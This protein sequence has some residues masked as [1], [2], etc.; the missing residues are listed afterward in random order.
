MMKYMRQFTDENNKEQSREKEGPDNTA[1]RYASYFYLNM[2]ILA[3]ALERNK[4]DI[5]YYGNEDIG[6]L[7]NIRLYYPD[8]QP[9]SSYVYLINAEDTSSVLPLYKDI[10]FIVKGKT[11]SSLLSDRRAA[12]ILMRDP[13]NMLEIFTDMQKVFDLYA[14]WNW[15]LQT[16]VEKS[17]P[18]DS[19]LEASIP[20][21]RNPVFIHDTNFFVLSDPHHIPTMSKWEKDPR[22]GRD[23][24]SVSTINDFRTD[25]EYLNGLKAREPV[26]FS[27]N[28]TGYRILFRNLWVN[29]HYMGRILIDEVENVIQPGDYYALDFLGDVVGKY[30]REKKIVWLSMGNDVDEFFADFLS[31]KLVD[32]RQAMTYLQ[33]LEWKRDDSYYCMRLVTDQ[34]EFNL[35]SADAILGQIDTALPESVSLYYDNS[36]TVIINLTTTG[37]TIADVISRLAIIIRESLL[38]VGVS[39]E[40]Q[41]FFMI[42]KAYQQCRIALDYGNL[43]SSMYWYYYFDSYVL[44]YIYDCAGREM[45]VELLNSSALRKL[46][47]YDAENNTEFYHT[48]M[49]YLKYERNVLRTSK[50]LFIHRS[51]LS[52]R[53]DRIKKLINVDLDNPTERLKLLLSFYIQEGMLS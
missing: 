41:D 11:D 35:L 6:K 24:V 13:V 12:V 38:K 16:A 52:Y 45:P 37:G 23:M 29:N 34:K 44:D 18:L 5:E 39:S 30:V 53:L 14:G 8:V 27:A 4:R 51:T 28:Q 15:D 47:T 19:M 7:A 40:I 49:V 50:E 22:T 20:V 3:D 25:M 9:V 32:D 21:F 43:S 46:K 31:E 26:M 2:R 33:Y 48:L 36:I 17:N 1:S 10:C 42:P